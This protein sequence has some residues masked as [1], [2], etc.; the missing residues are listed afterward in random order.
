MRTI[1]ENTLGQT[2]RE[3]REDFPFPL[4]NLLLDAYS[5]A[6]SGAGGA[7]GAVRCSY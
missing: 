2:E 1:S 6:V 7:G 4:D 3:A 5:Q